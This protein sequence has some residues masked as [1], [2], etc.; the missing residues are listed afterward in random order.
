MGDVAVGHAGLAGLPSTG[1]L[2]AVDVGDVRLGLAVSDAGQVVATPLDTVDGSPDEGAVATA[3]VGAAA[4][5]DACAVVVGYPRTM[6]GREG[7]AARRCR[8]V[9]EAVAER[10]GLPVLLW[11]ER[12]S[13]VEAERVLVDADLRRRRRRE[14]VDRV[15]ASLIL[16]G[17]LEARRPAGGAPR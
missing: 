13:T 10:S 3:V 8:L 9:A 16:Q 17:V 6:G 12:F 2:L 11:D 14:V 1:R 7:A 5:R 15:A 4:E